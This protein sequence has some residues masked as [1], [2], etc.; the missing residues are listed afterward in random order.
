MGSKVPHKPPIS[1]Q[2][3]LRF[4]VRFW[5]GLTVVGLLGVAGSLWLLNTV[6]SRDAF[7][8]SQR[9]SA[10][11]P[12]EQFSV[13]EILLREEGSYVAGRIVARVRY[14]RKGNPWI[15][16]L[17]GPDGQELLAVVSARARDRSDYV[18]AD[19]DWVVA[20]AVVGGRIE[21]SERY[22]Q[23]IPGIT[24]RMLADWQGRPFVLVFKFS[25]YLN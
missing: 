20:F 9:L 1:S 22:Y 25:R 24:H 23:R 8:E 14:V 6:F 2:V 18:P 12:Q 16:K 5:Y 17:R 3:F 7:T 19:G 4:T 13:E 21:D 15:L 11:D 10:L